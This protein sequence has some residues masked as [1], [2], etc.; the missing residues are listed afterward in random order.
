LQVF[1]LEGGGRRQGDEGAQL[2]EG[3]QGLRGGLKTALALLLNHSGSAFELQ[4][5]EIPQ[6]RP[7]IG[8]Q[9][10]FDRQRPGLPGILQITGHEPL[11]GQAQQGIDVLGGDPGE[12]RLG[13][14]QHE[15]QPLGGRLQAGVDLH[16]HR[17]PGQPRH[18]AFRRLTLTGI[19]GQRLGGHLG[20]QGTEHRGAGRHLDHLDLDAGAVERRQQRP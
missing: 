17:F 9:A 1:A 3:H 6:P 11:V 14:V 7:L 19:G 16:H 20:H 10:Q 5:F 18:Q 12:G 2:A 8:G 13:L 15:P 4:P